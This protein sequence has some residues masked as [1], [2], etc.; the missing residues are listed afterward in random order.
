MSA[1]ARWFRT[2]NVGLTQG[3]LACGFGASG[4]LM[5]LVIALVDRFGWRDSSVIFAVVTMVLCLPLAFLVKDPPD[6]QNQA[7]R[8][9]SSTIKTRPVESKPANILKSKNFWLFSLAILFGGAAATATL[10]HQI[11]YMVSVGI[12][13]QISGVLAMVLAV[14]SI[15]GRLLFGYLG[16]KIEPRLCFAICSILHAIGVLIF[17]L[18]TAPVQMIPALLAMGIGYGG[19]IPLRP[20]IQS[21]FFGIKFFATIQGFLMIAVT[22][23]VI[24]A[25][26]FSGWMF[27]ISGSYRT[28]FLILAAC[29]LLA[30]PLVMAIRKEQTE[31]SG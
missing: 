5:P 23:G 15:A 26:I 31:K 22:V 30:V 11:P 25:P 28:A 7:S 20:A 17:A 14:S 1:V 27:D 8:K 24:I 6:L 21:K 10:V 18:A 12:S 19:L 13:R 16:D 4:L 3:I 2:R 9:P 29:T